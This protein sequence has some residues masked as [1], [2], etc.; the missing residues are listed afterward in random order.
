MT[1]FD[2]FAIAFVLL[3]I[4]TLFAGVKTVPQGYDWTIERFGKYTRT[5]S[6][7]LNLIV[8]YF[9]RVGRKMNMMEQ[10]INIPEQE[11]ITKDNA[12]VTVDGVAFYP[13]VRCRQGELR[14]LQSRAGDHR[15]DHDQHPLGDGLDGSRPGAV[16][17]RRDQRAA[18]ARGRCRGVAVG[19][20]GQPHRDQG[21]RAAGRPRRGDGPADEGRARQARRHPAGRRPAPVGNPARR[22]RQAGPDPAGRRPPRG[23]LPRRRGARALR[24]SRGQGDADGLRGHRQGRRRRAELFHRRQIHQGVRA[25]CGFAEPEDHDAADRGDQHSGLARRHR[26]DREGDLRRKRGVRAPPRGAASVPNTGPRRRR[27]RRS[28]RADPAGHTV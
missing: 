23:R 27:S 25:A 11:V 5:L 22:R 19:P 14:G 4:V 1:G 7:G 8:P 18:V 3:V 17:S 26:R 12:T 10:V 21:H 13:G 20:Q 6:P 15:A 24:R 28:G 2:I 16:A 9:D